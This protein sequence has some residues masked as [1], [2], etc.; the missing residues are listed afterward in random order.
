M[1]AL[2]VA[3][4][5]GAGAAVRFVVDTAVRRAVPATFPLGILVV[6]AS[7]SLLLGLLTGALLDTAGD[8][9][10]LA[11]LGI[12]FCGGYTT[13][14]TA[15]VDTVRMLQDGRRR[16]ALVHHLGMA[17]VCLGAAGVGLAVTV[18]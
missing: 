10:V 12:G 1:T 6:N 4:A 16:A 2:L 14:G 13:F 9:Q 8:Q 5:G 17:V 3:L 15:M 7:G 11:V 18:R